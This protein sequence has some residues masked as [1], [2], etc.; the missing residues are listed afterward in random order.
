M[1]RLSRAISSRRGVGD[2]PLAG[3][4]WY[5]LWYKEPE[6][7]QDSSLEVLVSMAGRIEVSIEY[8]TS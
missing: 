5:K 4:P 3:I 8:C 6:K 2:P 7:N 1:Y